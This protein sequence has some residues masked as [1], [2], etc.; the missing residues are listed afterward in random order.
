MLEDFERLPLHS[1]RSGLLLLSELTMSTSCNAARGRFKIFT[2]LV[3]YLPA[4]S[5]KRVSFTIFSPCHF[6]NFERA[7]TSS[8]WSALQAQPVLEDG[9]VVLSGVGALAALPLNVLAHRSLG[10]HQAF[11]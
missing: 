11:S 10:G 5:C 9:R 7:N 3:V 2:H 6:S 4:F 1:R 8:W